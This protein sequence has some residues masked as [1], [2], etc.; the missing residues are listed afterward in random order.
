MLW[1][2]E[3][4]K[5]TSKK[6]VLI[7]KR[8]QLCSIINIKVK[9]EDSRILLIL[10]SSF[11]VVQHWVLLFFDTVYIHLLMENY[12]M[13]KRRETI[14]GKSSVTCTYLELRVIELTR[15]AGKKRILSTCLSWY[16]PSLFHTG[17]DRRAAA[18]GSLVWAST[19]VPLRPF[20]PQDSYFSI[21][22]VWKTLR[23]YPSLIRYHF[24]LKTWIWMPILPLLA[25]WIFLGE[26]F[27]P[28]LFSY[29]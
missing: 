7:T 3:L 21:T 8:R 26:F 20:S 12:Q 9:I 16:N 13:I 19:L 27:N 22:L 5:A 2:S 18:Y 29:L 15:Q 11:N 24:G 25:G 4:V 10:W 28:R 17:T 1:E 14:Y 6:E 23:D